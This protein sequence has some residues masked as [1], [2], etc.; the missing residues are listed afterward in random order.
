MLE[1]G[2]GGGG[3]P[4]ESMTL[5]L[6]Q[7]LIQNPDIEAQWRLVGA[8]NKSAQLLGD[9]LWQL[10]DYRSNLAAVWSPQKS[11]AAAAYLRRLDELISNLSETYEASVANHRAFALVTGSIDQAQAQM[12]KIYEEYRINRT[13]QSAQAGISS[14]TTARQE[15]LRLQAVKLLSSV[16][17]DLAQAQSQIV[18]PMPYAQY[19]KKGS[20]STPVGHDGEFVAPPL[21]QITPGLSIDRDASES[22]H[23]TVP[24][25]GSTPVGTQQQTGPVLGN[26]TQPLPQPATPGTGPITPGL[27]GREGSQFGSL[28]FLPGTSLVPPGE[29]T[30]IPTAP[31]SGRG[32]GVPRE[33]FAGPSSRLPETG[34]RAT[35][36]G[37]VGGMPG[38]GGGRQ[39]AGRP[40][41]RRINP[42]GGVIGNG[43]RPQRSRP[44]A[45]GVSLAGTYGQAPADRHHVRREANQHWDPDNPWETEVG[46][47]PVVLP[48]REQPI[49]P[50]PAIGL[51]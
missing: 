38:Y 12:H 19:R 2:G 24:S 7:R 1:P 28:G 15:E 36:P 39:G 25:A 46:V 44:G 22:P 34:T 40:R 10:R 49:D 33:G 3:T 23:A 8:W 16:S 13:I 18:K 41:T 29:Q 31:G 30:L 27:P 17:T 48:P 37:V 6:M 43:D 11:P 50:G 51:I 32:G 20:D 21:P 14:A 45:G 42:I 35:T 9:H 47:D 5:D 4:W 26:A